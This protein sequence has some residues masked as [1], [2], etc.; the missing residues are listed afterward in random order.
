LLSSLHPFSKKI[1][2]KRC[3]K[4]NLKKKME[5]SESEIE[6]Q[7]LISR[8]SGD[9]LEERGLDDTSVS[10]ADKLVPNDN[11]QSVQE[12]SSLLSREMEFL[13]IDNNENQERVNSFVQ[14]LS[15][16]INSGASILEL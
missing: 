11:E 14:G 3:N 2:I 7:N 8:P 4:F 5:N 16:I 1:L 15:H 10:Y 6:M 12:Q 13:E 9:G